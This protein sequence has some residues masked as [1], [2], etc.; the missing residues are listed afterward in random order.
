MKWVNVWTEKGGCRTLGFAPLQGGDLAK[1]VTLGSL[2]LTFQ[3]CAWVFYPGPLTMILFA[4]GLLMLAL[5]W[6]FLGM[7]SHPNGC[8]PIALSADLKSASAVALLSV[9]FLLSLA[10]F[11]RNFICAASDLGLWF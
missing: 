8:E 4:F 3:V 9:L 2:G 1:A 7:R 10:V 5:L 11:A 6:R